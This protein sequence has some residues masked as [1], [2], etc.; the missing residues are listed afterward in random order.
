[1]CSRESFN[2]ALNRFI[3]L[4]FSGFVA[5]GSTTLH[6]IPAAS[7]ER[8]SPARVPSVYAMHPEVAS[9]LGIAASATLPGK[10]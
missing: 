8:I 6:W 9:I 5:T 4:T 3:E 2:E 1:M 7:I 10:K